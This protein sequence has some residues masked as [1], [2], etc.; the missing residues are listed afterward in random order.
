MRI[1]VAASYSSKVNYD[2][3]D[4]FPEY[5]KWLE[6][7]LNDL[8]SYGYTVFCSLREDKYRINDADPA[9]AFK[10]DSAEIARCDAFLALLNA[11]V[12]AGVQTELGYALAL[13]KKVL[14]AHAREDKLSYINNA[15]VR[16]GR[17]SELILPLTAGTLQA[18][19]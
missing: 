3:G 12:S 5:R 11:H 6:A 4:V 2:M 7:L 13:K 1:F 9:A 17:A 8:E 14:F 10:L 16:T 18:V 19:L 15:I